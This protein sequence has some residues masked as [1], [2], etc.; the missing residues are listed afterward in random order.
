VTGTDPD[1][2]RLGDRHAK[3][4]TG[5]DAKGRY[6]CPLFKIA[7]ERPKSPTRSSAT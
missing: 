5:A 4:P 1:T 7:A 3:A 2:N 6:V